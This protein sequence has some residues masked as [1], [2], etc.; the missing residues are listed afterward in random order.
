M[1]VLIAVVWQSTTYLK[2]S[3]FTL[4]GIFE[5]KLP[6]KVNPTRF[7]GEIIAAVADRIGD[8]KKII[9]D[10][11]KNNDYDISKATDLIGYYVHKPIKNLDYQDIWNIDLEFNNLVTDENNPNKFGLIK[12]V[13]Y[14]DTEKDAGSNKSFYPDD[15]I[16]FNRDFR[17][18][19]FIEFDY[20]HNNAR[21]FSYSTKKI[22]PVAIEYKPANQIIRLNIPVVDTLNSKMDK[23]KMGS[24]V[25]AVGLYSPFEVNNF[26]RINKIYYKDQEVKDSSNL[27]PYYDF[28]CSDYK[29]EKGI[30][31]LDPVVV[32][33]FDEKI[34]IHNMDN[35]KSKLEEITSNEESSYY[36]NISDNRL[37]GA[38]NHY[39][40]KEY[41]DA[42]EIFKN[43]EN[44]SSEA[45]T[46]IGVIMAYNA[47]S[48]KGVDKK[49]Y[50]VNEAYRY[51]DKAQTLAKS[52]NDRF[53][54]L[55]NRIGVSRSVP[56]EVFHKSD[57][58]ENDLRIILKMD[59]ITNSEKARYYTYLID[60]Y[61]AK[62]KTRQIRLIM[63]DIKN[64]FI[65]TK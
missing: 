56:D 51:F 6:F 14:I 57:L 59:K 35:I 23:I 25:V 50:Y 63:E 24:H 2:R 32:N 12:G 40:D 43:Y 39:K 28:I 20:L 5:S 38:Y 22:Y 17:W 19:Y 37:V 1:I 10:N 15:N 52:D 62:N 48:A 11:Y 61:L 36:K 41:N 21:M 47:G 42:L 29:I 60:L 65:L 49:I 33:N 31:I 64:Y 16:S 18:D 46:Y 3:M 13:V 45:N 53:V 58:L 4:A 9:T 7:G 55:A 30:M 26:I 27:T 44:E 34:K 8:S 54:L